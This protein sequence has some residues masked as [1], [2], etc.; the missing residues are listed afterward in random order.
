VLKPNAY[1]PVHWDDFFAPF[2]QG[3]TKPYADPELQTLLEQHK[4]QLIRPQQYMDKWRL[5]ASGIVP[6]P[7]EVVKR[8][9]GFSDR[10][11]AMR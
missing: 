4:I 6:E 8:A 5:G 2:E 11:N 7:N 9:L 10:G 3:V 1:L